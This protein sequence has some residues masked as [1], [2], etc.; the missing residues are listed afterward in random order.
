MR[1]KCSFD[2]SERNTKLS[3]Y[4]R[5]LSANRVIG[6]WGT[7]FSRSLDGRVFLFRFFT[8]L[9]KSIVSFLI[10]QVF[11]SKNCLFYR[12]NTQTTNHKLDKPCCMTFL[13]PGDTQRRSRIDQVSPAVAGFGPEIHQPVRIPDY[14]NVML[15]YDYGMSLFDEGVKGCQQLMYIV[16]MEAGGW[17]IKNE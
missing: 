15:N 3:L 2:R 7:N 10:L 11:S 6:C 4:T 14:V 17:L 16:K 1:L 5:F 13:G 9:H 8:T 12:K